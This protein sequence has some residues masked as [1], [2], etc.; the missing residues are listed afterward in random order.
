MGAALNLFGLRKDGTEFPVDIMLKPI[1]TADGPAV[2]TFIRDATEQRAAQEALRL[3]DARLRSIVESI[4]EYAIYLLDRDGHILTWNPGAERIKGYKA[5]EVLGLHFS[6]FFTQEDVEQ[7]RPAEL[8]RQAI[9]KESRGR[10]GLAR[11]QG[12][13][14]L[15]GQRRD[16]GHPRQHR[17]SHGI[18]QDHARRDRAKAGAGVGDRRAEQLAAGQCG[19]SQ[20]AEAFSASMRQMVPHDAATLALYDEA[21]GKLRVQ[22]LAAGDADAP[23]G[24]VLLDPDASPAG[25]AFR[26]RRP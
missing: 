6:R 18:R 25:Q 16:H 22:F 5:D 7:G 12:R 13:L 17:R 21:T 20:A 3:N 9:A 26:T 10:R 19:H 14:P 8:L 4:G 11:A 23:Q 15:L 1:E 2:M 24:E